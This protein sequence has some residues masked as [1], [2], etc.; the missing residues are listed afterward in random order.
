MEQFNLYTLLFAGKW[1]LIGLIYFIL[2][3][4]LISVRREMVNRT[5]RQDHPEGVAAG[6]LKVIQAGSDKRN[7]PGNILLLKPET[8]LGAESDND[9]I[10]SDQ[11][12]SKHH[13]HLR[14]DGAIWWIEDLNSS[15]GTMVD[16]KV[17][18]PRIP[19]P[20]RGG[21]SLKLGDMLFELMADG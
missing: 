8:R 1:V 3:I 11:F 12:I 18:L 5:T 19:Q 17:C 4:I 20:I 6:R 16:G 10:I 2:I 7:L 13:A 9:L 14:W 15:N 21:A